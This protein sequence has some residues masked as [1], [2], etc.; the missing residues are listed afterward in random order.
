MAPPRRRPGPPPRAGR[1]TAGPPAGTG[2]VRVFSGTLPRPGRL[3]CLVSLDARSAHF[4]NGTAW[5]PVQR[6]GRPHPG[7]RPQTRKS[8]PDMAT[9]RGSSRWGRGRVQ[10]VKLLFVSQSQLHDLRPHAAHQVQP[11]GPPGIPRRV[12][13]RSGLHPD[14]GQPGL[15]EQLGCPAAGRRIGA[16][17]GEGRVEDLA[18]PVEG[19]MRR[20]AQRM[21]GVRLGDGDPAARLGQAHHLG[22]H[23]R[24]LWHVDQQGSGMGQVERARPEPGGPGV[25]GHDLHPPEPAIGDERGRHG[26][27]RRVGVKAY[28]P[29]AG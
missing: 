21:F 6:G 24:G 19:R 27:M 22:H 29:A 10:R 14:V 8:R 11:D 5:R 28:D 20:V 16:V 4:V 25:R 13:L 26:G 17:A 15:A 3:P 1:P 2:L 7:L 18:H 23:H 9:V 12:H